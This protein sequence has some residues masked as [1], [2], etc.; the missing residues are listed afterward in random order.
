MYYYSAS[1]RH[2]LHVSLWFSLFFI[3]D[4]FRFKHDDERIGSGIWRGDGC[5]ELGS[6]D[7]SGWDCDS[8][9][10]DLRAIDKLRSADR[11][12]HGALREA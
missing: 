1:L 8:V 2:L 10:E 9:P 6:G 4:R 11:D 7:I 12:G 5:G 3:S